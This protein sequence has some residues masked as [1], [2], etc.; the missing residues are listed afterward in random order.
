MLIAINITLTHL[1][2]MRSI[3]VSKV[4]Y[5]FGQQSVVNCAGQDFDDGATI[6][7]S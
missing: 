1:F 3:R 5:R 2:T 7:T 4:Y 6:R